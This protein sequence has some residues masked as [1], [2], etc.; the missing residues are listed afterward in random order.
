MID[1]NLVGQGQ[2]TYE[3][4]RN[5]HKN[6]VLSGCF[7]FFKSTVG[8]GL[9]ASQCFFGKAGLLLSFLV[10]AVLVLLIQYTMRLLTNVA[11]DMESKD[12]KL[13]IETYGQMVERVLG[14]KT[15]IFTLIACFE[16]NHAILIINTTNFAK[17]VMNQFQPEQGT[18]DI[19][20]YKLVIIGILVVSLLLVIEP[21][22]LKFTSYVSA[23]ALIGGTIIMW[24]MNLGIWAKRPQPEYDLAN[25]KY[26]SNYVG[27]QL[28]AIESIG[29]L[30][31]VRA[32]LRE[33]AKIDKVMAYTFVFILSMFLLNGS[34]F[35]IVSLSDLRQRRT[36]AGRFRLLR[37]L[38]ADRPHQMGFLHHSPPHLADVPGG[39]LPRDRKHRLRRQ[40]TEEP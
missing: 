39:E 28:Y 24:A 5:Y 4:L 34:S 15:K 26:F 23:V 22:K 37:K 40:T 31:T 6:G 1:Q 11:K 13:K 2:D 35:L 27:N 32:L 21:E 29:T 12:P 36:Q 8:L 10:S 33:P 16:F 20:M 14:P 38:F 3:S 17:F 18:G 30:F 7:I 25:F 19:S 9:L